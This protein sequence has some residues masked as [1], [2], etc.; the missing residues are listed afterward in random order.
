MSHISGQFLKIPI[1]L[2]EELACIC[3]SEV[4]WVYA[5]TLDASYESNNIAEIVK[6]SLSVRI[7]LFRS[8]NISVKSHAHGI[9]AGKL[10]RINNPK[11]PKLQSSHRASTMVQTVIHDP[12]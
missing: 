1:V 12:H 10:P 4:S 9:T 2:K 8:R 6:I 7:S 5:G 11:I 3:S